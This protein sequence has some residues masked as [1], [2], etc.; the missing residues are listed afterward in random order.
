MI[1]LVIIWIYFNFIMNI[2]LLYMYIYIFSI[3]FISCLYVLQYTIRYTIEK[4]KNLILNTIQF[5]TIML[6]RFTTWLLTKVKVYILSF[7]HYTYYT[8]RKIWTDPIMVLVLETFLETFSL[9]L[10][11]KIKIKTIDSF[12]S[13]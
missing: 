6:P 2:P 9:K 1:K 11:K 10:K 3:N 4:N 8:K 7:S 12:D 5:L 13:V